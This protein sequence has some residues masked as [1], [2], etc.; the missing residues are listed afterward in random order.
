MQCVKNRQSS[1]KEFIFGENITERVVNTT[2]ENESNAENAKE[3]GETAETE[4]KTNGSS[5]SGD[6]TK[7]ANQSTT[8]ASNWLND[9][10]HDKYAHDAV[11]NELYTL[12][13]I[14][15]K[16]YVLDAEKSNWNER[17]YGILKVIETNEGQNCK[18]SK[19]SSSSSTTF[20]KQ[21]V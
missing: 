20:Y 21:I 16:L 9:T 12:L 5:S 3:A 19:S 15:C 18:I 6:L 10:E 4:S 1:S 2:S 14:N 8:N 17:G 13:K 7:L 11:E